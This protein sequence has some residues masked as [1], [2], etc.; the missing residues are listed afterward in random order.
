[1]TALG[2]KQSYTG[3]DR[4]AYRWLFFQPEYPAVFLNDQAGRRAW[5][6][7]F[8]SGIPRL[9]SLRSAQEAIILAEDILWLL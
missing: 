6:K 2:I 8:Q 5:H 4:V 7:G 9:M 1:M 3:Q